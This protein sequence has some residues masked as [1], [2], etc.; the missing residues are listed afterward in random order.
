MS[1][2]QLGCTG[3]PK[4]SPQAFARD[5]VLPGGRKAASKAALQTQGRLTRP[6]RRPVLLIAA[7]GIT[8]LQH[9]PACSQEA[10]CTMAPACFNARVDCSTGPKLAA[11]C[12]IAHKTSAAGLLGARLPTA[13]APDRRR[14]QRP[15]RA[16]TASVAAA[17]DAAA[18]QWLQAT[19]VPLL[20]QMQAG[21]LQ[22]AAVLGAQVLVGL[23]A[24]TVLGR[25][26]LRAA[27]RRVSGAGAP[28]GGLA[29]TGGRDAGSWAARAGRYLLSSLLHQARALLPWM[30][31]L[32]AATTVACL[33][34]VRSRGRARARA[35]LKLMAHPSRRPPST[36]NALA[37]P[38]FPAHLP[39]R[40]IVPPGRSPR[41]AAPSCCCAWWARARRAR[42]RPPWPTSPSSC[43]TRRR[44]R[45]SCCGA[46]RMGSAC[47]L[48]APRHGACWCC[49]AAAA[50]AGSRCPA[51]RA[52]AAAPAQPRLP[53]PLSSPRPAPPA[54][55]SRCSS[56]RPGSWSASRCG[57][58]LAEG[59][60]ACGPRRRHR[61]R[62]RL[63][64]GAAARLVT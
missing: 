45:S 18:D 47:M 56:S 52:L 36:E 41:S 60:A 16:V 43:R 26:F 58:G 62:C 19:G 9:T 15:V 48:L 64:A 39:T 31:S 61:Q 10:A 50:G 20:R 25:I 35:V 34:Q 38:V 51:A 13:G 59:P 32:C 7:P 53:V 1:H 22:A 5:G 14:C 33:L 40:H 24:A 27:D 49:G 54:A 4:L 8:R 23:A 57:Q 28:T 30:S 37:T 63:A 11:R 44:R 55:P 46:R 42:R 17:V 6:L 29:S 2:H 12:T 3:K 21:S